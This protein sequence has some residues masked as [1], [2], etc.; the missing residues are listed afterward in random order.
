LIVFAILANIQIQ[1]QKKASFMNEQVR[2]MFREHPTMLL[3]F[4]YFIITII[5]VL[6]SYF[7]Y[8][9]FDI[10]IVK[11]ADLSDFLLASILEPKSILIFISLIIVSFV[12]HKLDK[13]IRKKYKI[14]GNFADKKLKAKYTD[15]IG[16]FVILVFYTTVLVHHLAVRNATQVKSGSSDDFLVRISD[17]GNHQ[18]EKTLAL[19]GSSSRYLYFYSH[20]KSETQVIPVENVSFMIKKVE[21]V[22]TKD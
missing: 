18:V 4:C 21:I 20:K 17:P 1:E 2:L 16:Y 9:E 15:P 11:F 22:E 5:G 10:N 14:Y 8:N 19:L 7:F 13:L 12:F 6:Y 3:T